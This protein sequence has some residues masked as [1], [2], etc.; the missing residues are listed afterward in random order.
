[1]ALDGGCRAAAPSRQAGTGPVELRITRSTGHSSWMV[2]GS[3]PPR[4]SMMSSATRVPAARIDERVVDIVG[5][6]RSALRNG[7]TS[8][9]S[10]ID[11]SLPSSS[12]PAPVTHTLTVAIEGHEVFVKVL[13][14]GEQVHNGRIAVGA[15]FQGGKKGLSIGYGKRIGRA[16]FSLGSAFSGS[17]RSAGVGLGLDL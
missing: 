4:I 1:M 3:R 8:S 12:P 9:W 13:S 7:K 14:D 15:G 16:S 6:M 10:I 5:T 11:T 17:E 2:C